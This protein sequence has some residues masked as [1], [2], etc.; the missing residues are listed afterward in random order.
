M[1]LSHFACLLIVPLTLAACAIPPSSNT[2]TTA[3]AGT[4]QDVQFGT[5]IGL[6]DVSIQEDNADT[7]KV[8]GG[9]IGGVAGSDIG[10]GKGKII[11]GVAGAVIGGT[12]GMAVDR[13]LQA[14]PGV[15]VT[16]RLQDGRTVA[17][18][19][20]SDEPFNIG[21]SVKILTNREGKARVTH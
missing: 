1:K 3:Q 13:S 19:Q 20:L 11:G 16:A 14:K 2:Y 5:V 4:L 7:G 18:A 9:V 15:E 10:E 17:I 6:R 21:D 8:A 12:I